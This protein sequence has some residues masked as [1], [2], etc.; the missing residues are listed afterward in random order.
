[1]EAQG[2]DDSTGLYALS[3]LSREIRVLCDDEMRETLKRLWAPF[4]FFPF[5]DAVARGTFMAALLTTAARSALPT[6]PGIAIN[7]QSPGTGKTLMLSSLALLAGASSEDALVALSDDR[8]EQAKQLSAYLS[9]GPAALAFDNKDGKF[10]A[11]EEFCIACTSPSYRARILGRTETITLPNR[12]LWIVSGNNM[13]L[14]S[15]VIRRFL[16]VNLDSPEDP[17]TR[18]FPFNPVELV[19]TGFMGFR[20]D[21]LDIFATFKARGRKPDGMSGY[22][23]F[24][25]WND[26][27]RGCLL[28]ALPLMPVEME[29]P[30]EGMKRA[31]AE[32]PDRI[33]LSRML[34]IWQRRFPEGVAVRDIDSIPCEGA[35]MREWR[36]LY[37]ECC[38]F[39]GRIDP[40]RLNYRMRHW[41]GRKVG[42]V[43]FGGGKDR[44][45]AT[46]WQVVP[47]E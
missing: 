36:E 17:E 33:L 13:E 7:A 22:A 23:S 37:D 47:A 20:E 45:G 18:R 16:M 27:V 39:K 14:Q 44:S 35:L 38:T 43:K 26:L 30:L 29:D 25:A 42:G 11:S 15:D 41:R 46:V 3:G 9:L 31:K 2:L 21:L 12:A 19:E 32:D 40:Q 8:S 6:A 10:K 4:R 34:S 24:E 1:M 28:W 5:E